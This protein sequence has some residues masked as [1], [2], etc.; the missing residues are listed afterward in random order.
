MFYYFI[1]KLL[2]LLDPEKAHTLVFKYLNSKKV[3]LI[4]DFFLHMK[5]HQ[6]KLNV[7]D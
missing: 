5:F 4:R 3:Q 1:R 2:F 7:W 6:K